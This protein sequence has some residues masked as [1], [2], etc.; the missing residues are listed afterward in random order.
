MGPMRILVA[1]NASRAAK[2]HESMMRGFALIEIILIL[3]L[4]AIVAAMAMP[5]VGDMTGLN[6]SAT[7]EKLQSDIGYAQELAMTRNMRHRVYFNM[8][9]QSPANGYAVVNDVNGNAIW[10]EA[11]EI[12]QD[13]VGG[14]NLEVAL[15]AGPYLG[16]TIT[17][18]G[19]G[20]GGN[21]IEFNT[22]GVPYNAGAPWGAGMAAAARQVTVSG[23]GTNQTVTLQPQTGMVT[24][25]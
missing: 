8:P 4:L 7:A 1:G 12:A 10:G 2:G 24:T 14:G 20:F 16:I 17:N 23:G 3:V 6:A 25:P 21:Y 22:L 13:P 9:P 15:N 11:G 19:A 18:V 5:S